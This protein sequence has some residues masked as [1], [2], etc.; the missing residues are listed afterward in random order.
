MACVQLRTYYFFMS[1]GT[2]VR[3]QG[4][5][6]SYAAAVTFILKVADADDKWSFTHFAPSGVAQM[7][8]IAAMVLLKVVNSSYANHID[9]EE[10]RRAFN[11]AASL[12]RKTSVEDN[13]LQGRVNKIIAQLWSLHHNLNQR[14]E[15]EP[16][17][18]IN[19]RW[20][21]SLLHD[22]LWTWREEFGGQK[23]LPPVLNSPSTSSPSNLRPIFTGTVSPH[24]SHLLRN[25]NWLLILMQIP[26]LVPR[27]VSK[28][29]VRKQISQKICQ[30]ANKIRPP[31]HLKYLGLTI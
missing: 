5:L 22:S 28:G 14:K 21:A 1:P 12:I 30:S 19:T 4:L 2:D 11:T 18:H 25:K 20:G 6:K 3:K 10:G 23:A 26:H 15:E 16:T 13:D 31:G 17:V 24:C 27:G 29:G 8:T 9:T 7:L